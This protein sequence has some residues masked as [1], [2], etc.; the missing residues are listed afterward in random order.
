MKLILLYLNKK[1]CKEL[2]KV[3][4]SC[5]GIGRSGRLKKKVL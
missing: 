1:T 4:K 3:E 5:Y 2:K